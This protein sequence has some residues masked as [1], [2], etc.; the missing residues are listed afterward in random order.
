VERD[1]WSAD[2]DIDRAVSVYTDD[3]EHD[4]VGAPD[5]VLHG[6]EAIRMR[7]QHLAETMTTEKMSRLHTY[8]SPNACVVEHEWTGQ[9]I[10]QIA[11]VDGGGRRVSFRLLHV[12]EFRE[13][14]IS[15]ENVWMDQG[16]MLAQ[17]QLPD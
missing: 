1:R 15:R 3:I 2:N 14:R 12:F 16:A 5:G 17:L 11:G 10:G 7:Y 13:G 9:V 8:Y 4:V 6:A